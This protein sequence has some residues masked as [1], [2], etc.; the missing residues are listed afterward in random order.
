MDNNSF[1]QLLEKR[2]VDYYNELKPIQE[3]IEKLDKEINRL[4]DCI[5]QVKGLIATENARLKSTPTPSA[6]ASPSA[7][8]DKFMS[9]NIREACRLIIKEN[10][11]IHADKL[12][13]ILLEGGFHFGSK[14]PKRMVM[15]SLLKDHLVERTKERIYIW[16]G[17]DE[18]K[19]H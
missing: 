9:M 16:Q 14:N 5:V 8:A 10:K 18:N 4:S 17:D 7:A 13:K 19:E 15:A 12:I 2:L 11:K 3:E 1:I 6:S